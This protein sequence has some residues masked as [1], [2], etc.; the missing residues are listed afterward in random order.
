MCLYILLYSVFLKV[1][2]LYKQ[3]NSAKHYEVVRLVKFNGSIECR[4]LSGFIHTTIVYT[5]YL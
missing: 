5:L 1:I 3:A 2:Y 4:H